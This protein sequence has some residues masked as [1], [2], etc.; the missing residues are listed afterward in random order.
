ME[1]AILR[2]SICV[3]VLTV[4]AVVA[5]ACPRADITGDCKVN[6][7]DFAIMASQWLI[8]GSIFVTTW[9][10]SLGAGTTVTL[11]IAGTCERYYRLGG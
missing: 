6:L 11:A 1:K 10:T 3:V 7:E 5:G 9:D 4:F 2:I 8:D